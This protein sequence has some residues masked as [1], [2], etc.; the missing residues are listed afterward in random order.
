[1]Y[2]SFS[3]ITLEQSLRENISHLI[4]NFWRDLFN[5][6]E[7]QQGFTRSLLLY[8]LFLS[9]IYNFKSHQKMISS[10]ITVKSSKYETSEAI[11]RNKKYWKNV[12]SELDKGNEHVSTL[13]Q[14]YYI[15]TTYNCFNYFLNTYSIVI[16]QYALVGRIWIKKPIKR[17]IQRPLWKSLCDLGLWYR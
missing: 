4:T 12:I 15:F 9:L 10:K 5:Y 11:R 13:W 6:W 2:S 3:P 1:M 14:S 16:V 7:R 8:I 17:T